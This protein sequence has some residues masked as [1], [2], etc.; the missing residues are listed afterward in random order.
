MK[1]Y[2][3]FLEGRWNNLKTKIDSSGMAANMD[4]IRCAFE[5]AADSHEGQRRKDG[6]PF[7]THTIAAAELVVEM[8]LDE[9]SVVAALLHDTIED[10]SVTY[11]MIE[12]RFGSSVAI[13]VDGVTKLNRVNFSSKEQEQME[14]MRKMLL[15]MCKDIRVILIKLAD[16][17][18]NMRTMDYQTPE[19]QRAKSLETMQVYAPIAHRLG[20]QRIKW[21]LEDLALKYL[22]PVG[23]A[24][25]VDTLEKRRGEFELFLGGMEGKI[26]Q[27]LDEW[28]IE[29]TIS[30]RIKHIYSIYRKMYTQRL[31]L[32]EIFDLCALRVIVDTLSDCYNVLGQVHDMYKPIPGRIKDYIS[33][34]K[35]N[36]Y[37]SLHTTVIGAEGIPF[38]VQI[39]TW[40][41]H[42]TAEYG[43]AAHWKYKSGSAGVRD[44]DEEKFAW[45]RRLLESQQSNDSSD[46][47]TDLRLDMFSD[48]VFVFT[49][50]GD[51]VSLP[52]GATPIDFAYKIHSA[53]GNRMVGAKVNGRIVPFD[54][55]LQNGDIVDILTSKA[56]PGPSRDWLQIAKSG[57]ARTKIK[58][59]FKRERR[60]ENIVRGHDMLDAE[61]RRIGI[62]W[63]DAEKL[64]LLDLIVQRLSLSCLD[65]LYAG[66]GYGGLSAQTTANRVREELNKIRKAENAKTPLE[67]INEAGERRDAQQQK[68]KPRPIQGVVVEGVDNCLIKFARC[69]TPVPGD[70]IIGFITRGYGVSVHRKDCPNYLR[71]RDNP[72]DTG[73]WIGVSWAGDLSENYNTSLK[74]CANNRDGLV[75]DVAAAL[76]E[77]GAKVHSLMARELGHGKAV[78]NVS[79]EVRDVQDLRQVTARVS[80]VPG[81]TEISRSS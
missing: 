70:D 20:M 33:T 3:D 53:I 25:I 81:I 73:R 56:A 8:G 44:G 55:E 40:D 45:V 12:K 10:T 11:E 36:G 68:K 34:P 24:T 41:M 52:T 48:E 22:D 31:D 62:R 7:V 38:E 50:K 27:R 29:C 54:H 43:V 51:V 65:D 15:A 37:Q 39:R 76:T 26:R 79:L 13:I 64:G 30:H 6:T 67:R 9:D 61:F 78:M 14:N 57:E 17:L 46:F 66:I 32:P 19:K 72:D 60:D 35:P 74:I 71:N 69:C 58:Q 77:L 42:R 28:E 59:W 16:R 21:E 2:D 75:M 63:A 18:H 80:T 4:R 23:Y 49:P 1:T 5:T 47:L